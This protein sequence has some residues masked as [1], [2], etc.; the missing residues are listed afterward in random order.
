[1]PA[2]IGYVRTWSATARYI[3][4]NGTAAV[5]RLEADL[6]V[7]WGDPEKPRVVDAPLYL[8]AGYAKLDGD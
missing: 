3:A 1:L 4:E 7:H 5:E 2:F 6:G 8:R